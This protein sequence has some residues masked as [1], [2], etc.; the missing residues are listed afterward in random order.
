MQGSARSSASI[1]HALIR[2]GGAA[3]LATLDAKGAP[4]ASYVLTASG[5]DGSPTLLLSNLA[6]HSRNLAR[7]TRAS[8]L[9]VREP[10]AGSDAATALRLTLTGQ[11]SVDTNAASRHLFLARHP[12]A[13]HYADFED[14]A[15]YRFEIAAGLLIAGFGRIVDLTPAE[16]LGRPAEASHETG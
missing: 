15:F 10:T 14:F 5:A 8:L 3:A 16:L 11:A 12:D 1:A 2:D 7:D 4:F 13:A 9:F 6:V